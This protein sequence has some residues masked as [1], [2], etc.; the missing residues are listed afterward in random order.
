MSKLI[1]LVGEKY[2]NWTVLE[3]AKKPEDSKSSSAFWLCRCDCG[4]ERIVSGNVL[5]QGKSKSCGCKRKQWQLE[6]LSEDLTGQRFGHLVVL[7]RAPRPET[8]TSNGSYWLCKCDCGNEKVIM[9]KSLRK[10]RTVSCGCHIQDYDNLI[11]QRFGKLVVIDREPKT[12]KWTCQCDCGNITY[13]AG[14]NLK[15]G[16]TQSCGCIVSVGEYKIEKLLQLYNILYIK[17]YSFNDLIGPNKGL[18]R[19][20][21]AIIN[22][23]SIPTRLIEFQGEQHYPTEQSKFFDEQIRITDKMK[24][25]YCIKHNIDLVCIPYWKRDTLTIKD[26][27]SNKYIIGRAEEVS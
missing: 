4:T 25:D 21:F 14:N 13:V 6:S 27:L 1:N 2:G 17:Q 18:L 8:V 26:L 10:G 7:C 5:K 9:G 3:K 23:D 19:F 20:D 16:N 15:Q 12:G 22:N 11:G 24:K